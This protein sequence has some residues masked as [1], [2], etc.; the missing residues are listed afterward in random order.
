MAGGKYKEW[1]EP[2]GLL[3]IEAWARD[4]LSKEQVAKNMGIAKSTLREWVNTYPAIS[5]AVKRG[6]EI[7]DI[8][9]ENAM[10]KR[11]LGYEYEEVKTIIEQTADGS[12][13]TKVEKTKKQVAPDVGAQIFWLKNRRSNCGWRILIR[14]LTTTNCWNLRRRNWNQRTGR[15]M[16]LNVSRKKYVK[17]TMMLV[18]VLLILL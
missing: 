7:V 5:T 8:E 2:D 13:K 18:N 3:R 10:C 15:N 1:L 9:V 4:G 6:K 11:A 17:T 16:N 14:L 12:R